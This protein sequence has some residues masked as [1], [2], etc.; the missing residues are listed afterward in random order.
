MEA[1]EREGQS[2]SQAAP[3]D[4]DARATGSVPELRGMA[5]RLKVDVD[6]KTIG[7]IT[8]RDGVV[9]LTGDGAPAQ[10]ALSFR[11]AEEFWKIMRG[12][13]NPVVAGLR[14]RLTFSG[15]L[16]FAVRVVLAIAAARPFSGPSEQ[17]GR[18]APA[19][20]GA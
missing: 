8:V 9:E 2:Q 16:T 4:P 19:E 11:S 7:A 5:G 14:G 15:D 10:A 13:F 12:E 3:A 17:T 20:K 6:G 1:G 18:T